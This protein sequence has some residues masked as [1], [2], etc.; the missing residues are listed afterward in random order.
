MVALR[1]DTLV[2][3]DTAGNVARIKKLLDELAEPK[4]E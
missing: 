4:K 3:L 2:V 1:N